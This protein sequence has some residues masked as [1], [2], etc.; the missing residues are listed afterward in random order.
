[1]AEGKETRDVRLLKRPEFLFRVEKVMTSIFFSL[2]VLHEMD[3]VHWKE[4]R[5]FGIGDDSI[6]RMIF[7]AVHLPM[8][9]FLFIAYSSYRQ[10]WAYMFCRGLAMFLIVHF[11]LHIWAF[12]E[13]YFTD[14]FS[15]G[16]IS[17]MV[18]ASAAFLLISY[19]RTRSSLG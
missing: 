18:P 11:M 1:M 14:V 7:I 12:S 3:A 9:I 6:G 10:R 17:V 13:G 5:L 19:L 15:F 4:W 2:L 8:L 16:L